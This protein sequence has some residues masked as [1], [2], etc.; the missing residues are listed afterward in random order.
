MSLVGLPKTGGDSV[1]DEDGQISLSIL[2]SSLFDP[3]AVTMHGSLLYH[4]TLEKDEC[5]V[6]DKEDFRPTPSLHIM[7]II[8]LLSFGIFQQLMGPHMKIDVICDVT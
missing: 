5:D 3:P 8:L 2:D 7:T 6:C 4:S 1:A